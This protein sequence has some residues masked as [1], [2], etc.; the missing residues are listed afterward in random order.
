MTDFSVRDVLESDLPVLFEIQADADGQFMAAFADTSSDQEKY[1]R[2][3]RALLADDSVL[4]KVIVMD[5]EVIGSAASFVVEGDTEV[6]YWIRREFW[7]R[8][9][10]TKALAALLAE[11]PA[12]PVLARAAHD[13][14]G[15]IRVLERNGFVRVGEE[16][17]YAE[18]RRSDIREFI[19]RLD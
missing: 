13:N 8:G 10:A 7:C 19:F 18:A 3:H 6:T 9:I 14:I 16:K 4:Q 17:S 12:R 2:K 15:S 5:G 1:L 11:V